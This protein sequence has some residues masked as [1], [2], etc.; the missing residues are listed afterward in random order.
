[1]RGQGFLAKIDRS[2]ISRFF[3]AA[4]LASLTLLLFACPNPTS[5]D[6]AQSAAVLSVV[7]TVPSNGAT[8]FDPGQTI[9]V[10]F[11]KDLD[12][13]CLADIQS[14][15]VISPSILTAGSAITLSFSYDSPNKKLSIEPH[16]Y[17]ESNATYIV[18][19][20]TNLKDASG[21]TLPKQ[22]DF[23]FTTGAQP[24]GDIQI[25]SGAGYVTT[26]AQVTLSVQHNATAAYMRFA[27]SAAD[28]PLALANTV[29][30]PPPLW[31]LV[32]TGDGTR[33][34]FVQFFDSSNNPSAVRSISIVRDTQPPT[35]GTP[36]VPPYYNMY[37]DASNPPL[38][39]AASATDAT[40]GVA[41]YSWT[42][43]QGVTFDT[44][45]SPNTPQSPA[46][47][48]NGKDRTYNLTLTVKDNA[49]NPA[50]RTLA[51]TKATIPPGPP[52]ESLAS[53]SYG[54]NSPILDPNPTV[55]W[56][57]EAS[58]NLGLA[59]DTFMEKLDT[60]TKWTSLP[61]STPSRGQA[62][63][64]DGTYKLAVIQVDAA[65]N[66]SQTLSM[67]IVVTP[68]SPPNKSAVYGP[69]VELGWRDF[70][71]GVGQSISASQY[72]VHLWPSNPQGKDIVQTS[73]GNLRRSIYDYLPSGQTYNWYVEFAPDGLNYSSHI[74]TDIP[75]YQFTVVK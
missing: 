3:L 54:D 21:A 53:S 8:G 50:V 61:L 47:K 6:P 41:S 60:E 56:V 35:I 65:G 33:T 24:A 19:F 48:I 13:S 40:S 64:S 72:R 1:M 10:N 2:F 75:Y 71:S 12:P 46:I 49:G 26:T 5:T 38:R 42:G 14:P 68:V 31:T 27:N 18:S 28:L 23:S 59:P 25:N 58:A 55:N 11:N 15:V 69:T 30:T 51:I 70:T 4:A 45:S 44:T 57:W 36:A 74:P 73:A 22:V 43:D 17:L 63:L 52:T 16:P 66:Q 37:N 9:V 32:P 34:V 67:Q 20:D 7:A 39:L 29:T 62:A